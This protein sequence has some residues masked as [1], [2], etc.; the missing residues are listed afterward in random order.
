METREAGAAS[1]NG[2]AGTAV[3]TVAG[4]IAAVTIE[5]REALCK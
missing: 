3:N 2:V 5:T 1:V 4:L